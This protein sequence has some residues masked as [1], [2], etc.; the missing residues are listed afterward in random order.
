MR[1]DMSKDLSF[2]M[3]QR[4]AIFYTMLLHQLTILPLTSIVSISSLFTMSGAAAIQILAKKSMSSVSRSTIVATGAAV[5]GAW[6]LMDHSRPQ[7]QSL[8]LESQFG[9]SDG[10]F[11]TATK[12]ALLS[13]LPGNKDHVVGAGYVALGA[14]KSSDRRGMD[15]RHNNNNSTNAN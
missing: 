15:Q 4:A 6:Y 11:P 2:S 5:L 13:R 1:H 7:N 3:I 8:S 9:T 10:Y 14:R 12:G